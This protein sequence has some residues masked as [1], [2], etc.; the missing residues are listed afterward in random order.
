MQL[1][2]LFHALKL[3]MDAPWFERVMGHFGKPEGRAQEGNRKEDQLFL[4]LVDIANIYSKL[5]GEE[6]SLGI[7]NFHSC[8]QRII[9]WCSKISVMS[10]GGD[11][12]NFLAQT[13]KWPQ[14][15]PP[16]QKHSRL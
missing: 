7:C 15:T 4:S 1:K 3:V 16:P 13:L 12:M 5:R 10:V 8:W 9:L 14:A 2:D 6:L 11:V